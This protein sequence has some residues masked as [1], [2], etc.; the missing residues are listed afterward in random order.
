MNQKIP[1]VFITFEGIDGSGKSTQIK[2]LQMKLKQTGR[3]VE[4]FR[5]PGGTKVSEMI[6]KILLDAQQQIDPVAELLL[7]SAA[8]SQLI[9]EKVIPMLD[10]GVVVILD[11]YYDSTTAY[12]GY[13]REAADLEEIQRINR[14]ATRDT[15][16][17]L[18]FYMHLNLEEAENRTAEKQKDRMEMSGKEFYQ[19]VI[20]GF[21][22]LAEKHDRIYRI[23]STRP[24]EEVSELIWKEVSR[25]LN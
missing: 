12:Q 24:P 3:R 4:V 19:R 23:D 8:R 15:E 14:I 13:G 20:K 1:I 6:R 10:D 18:T 2:L 17:D 25:R 22:Q 21:N 5:E 11:R 16:P 7:F 9:S